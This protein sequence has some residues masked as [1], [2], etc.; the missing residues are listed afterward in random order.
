METSLVWKPGTPS[1]PPQKRMPSNQAQP[2]SVLQVEPMER[3]M[4]LSAQKG[5]S[6]VGMPVHL[7]LMEAIRSVAV[8]AQQ[9]AMTKQSASDYSSA[10]VQHDSILA[11]KEQELISDHQELM[12]QRTLAHQSALRDLDNRFDMEREEALDAIARLQQMLT[13]LPE[14][15]AQEL[16]RARQQHQLEVQQMAASH[17]QALEALRHDSRRQQEATQESRRV[18][19]ERAEAL[20]VGGTSLK[21]IVAELQ[22]QQRV[23]WRTESPDMTAMIFGMAGR[24]A[25]DICGQACKHF[26]EVL[27]KEPIRYQRGWACVQL[28]SK[29][30]GRDQK[31]GRFSKGRRTE[32]MVD[33]ESIYAVTTSM[34]RN[35]FICGGEDHEGSFEHTQEDTVVHFKITDI[36]GREKKLL[37]LSVKELLENAHSGRPQSPGASKYGDYPQW[38]RDWCAKSPPLSRW[39]SNSSLT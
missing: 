31:D 34:E 5:I 35:Q 21:K 38:H 3:V 20:S 9:V 23:G 11:A 33:G 15:R 10:L 39:P 29:T 8:N 14:R 17:D 37:V 28:S 7:L 19:L 32:L 36:N 1:K 18:A 27:K 22:E 13:E 2:V 6:D 26:A 30:F 25:A 12:S 24:K 16:A 4:S